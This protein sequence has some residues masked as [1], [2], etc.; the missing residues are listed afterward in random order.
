MTQTKEEAFAI[1]KED[2]ARYDIY[3]GPLV[4]CNVGRMNEVILETGVNLSAGD[5]RDAFVKCAVQRA[6][7]AVQYEW[8]SAD[9]V[10]KTN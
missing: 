3:N 6:Y 7:R 8:K 1:L 10:K 9:D 2:S 5:K 4:L